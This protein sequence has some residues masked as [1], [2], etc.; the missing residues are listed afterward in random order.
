MISNDFYQEIEH[1]PVQGRNYKLHVPLFYSDFMLISASYLAPLERIETILPSSRLKPYRITP[2]HGVVSITV[3]KYRKCDIGP[4]NEVGVGIPVTLDQP[5]PLF[6]GLIRP[7]PSNPFIYSHRLPVTT[8]IAMDVG[9]EFAGYPKFIAEI[10]FSEE[11]NWINCSLSEA[12]Q[13]IIKFSGKIINTI[14]S[15]RITI[16]P[17]THR[18]GYL[19][20]SELILDDRE[21]GSSSN[22]ND[23]K[24]VLGEHPIS[25]E[26]R[27]LQLGRLTRYLYCPRVQ[28][29]LTPF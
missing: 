6:T 24:L 4:Y 1:T 17:I 9:K 11:G 5:T 10:D 2:W 13:N 29:I 22:A 3:Y 12:G 26:L 28:G 23:V 15:Q 14:T 20:R 8:R 19:L 27:D 25:D 16:N 18:N 7:M 21:I